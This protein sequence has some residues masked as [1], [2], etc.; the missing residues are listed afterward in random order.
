MLLPTALLQIPPTSNFWI[1]DA[2]VIYAALIH[3]SFLNAVRQEICCNS[4]DKAKVSA[5]Q[6]ICFQEASS[7]QVSR[8]ACQDDLL[9]DFPTDHSKADRAVAPHVVFLAFF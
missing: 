7:L 2:F 6:K 5:R 1:T 8:N 3:N 4:T 9:Q